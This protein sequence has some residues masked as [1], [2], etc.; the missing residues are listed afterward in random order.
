MHKLPS[1]LQDQAQEV[2]WGPGRRAGMVAGRRGRWLAGCLAACA[3]RRRRQQKGAAPAHRLLPTLHALPTT[4]TTAIPATHLQIFHAKHAR[5]A[6][7][8]QAERYVSGGAL[9]FRMNK[10]LDIYFVGGF[11]TVQVRLAL[12]RWLVQGVWV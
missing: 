1:S 11:G 3:C 12:L 7:A 6:R 10:I 2:R 8:N 5:R 9:Y 4:A